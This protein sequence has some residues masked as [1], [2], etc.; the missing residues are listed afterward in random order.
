MSI[1]IKELYTYLVSLMPNSLACDWDNDGLM[2]CGNEDAEV[3]K[4]LMTL[5]VTNEAVDYAIDNNCNVII[6]HHPLIFRPIKSIVPTDTT[7]KIAIKAL[8]NDLTV[9]SFHTRLDA[10]KNGVN[11]VLCEVLGVRNTEAFGPETEVIGK[12]GDVDVTDFVSFA[13]EVKDKLSADG[14]KITDAGKTVNRVAVLGGGGKDFVLPAYFYGA[15][16]FVTGEINYNT[17]VIAK[18]LGINVIEAGH[19][20]TE[21][22]VLKRLVSWIEERFAGLAFEYFVS[23][24]TKSI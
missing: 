3:N 21:A 10:A 13:N 7:T 19:Y 9:M 15:D 5:D 12:I 2:V 16:T 6:S 1:K 24:S 8:K 17:A 23:N 20:F 14:I 22:P 4:I 18:D 11:D